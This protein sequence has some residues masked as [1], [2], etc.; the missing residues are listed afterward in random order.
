MHVDLGLNG[1]SVEDSEM[2]DASS[3]KLES[4][5]KFETSFKVD[6]AKQEKLR[7]IIAKKREFGDSSIGK[8]KNINFYM[9]KRNFKEN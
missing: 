1:N 5:P 4:T 7:S 8:G 3:V 6:E 2:D 9:C